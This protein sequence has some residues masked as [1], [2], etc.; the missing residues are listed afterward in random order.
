MYPFWKSM[1]LVSIWDGRKYSHSEDLCDVDFHANLEMTRSHCERWEVKQLNSPPFTHSSPFRPT[2]D[3]SAHWVAMAPRHPQQLTLSFMNLI[4]YRFWLLWI[5]A[6]RWFYLFPGLWK[7]LGGQP[8]QRWMLRCVC[9]E[10]KAAEVQWSPGCLQLSS[11]TALLHSHKVCPFFIGWLWD[12][13]CVK[14]MVFNDVSLIP[15]RG[16]AIIP[17]FD[18]QMKKR[19]HFF[20]APFL[21]SWPFLMWFN[22]IKREVGSPYSRSITYS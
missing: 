7:A 13:D 1:G 6:R 2:F 22:L 18:V 14:V 12:R 17:H 11:D 3:L 19:G 21:S 9:L 20:P 5:S 10:V 8:G 15:Y 16:P 4:V